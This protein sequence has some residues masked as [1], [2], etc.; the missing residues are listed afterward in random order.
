MVDLHGKPL[1]SVVRTSTMS[2]AALSPVENNRALTT[3]ASVAPAAVAAVT[4]FRRAPGRDRRPSIRYWCEN[5]VLVVIAFR[6]VDGN[7]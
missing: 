4:T 3:I 1:A 2:L 7:Q 6:V 5:A